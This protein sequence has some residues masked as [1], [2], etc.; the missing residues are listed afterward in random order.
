MGLFGS[1]IG[2]VTSII[3]GNAQKKAASKAAD[4]Q[5]K[6]AQMAIDEQRRQFDTTQQNF[7]PYLGAGTSALDQI[8]SLL[9]I[10]TP[11]NTTTDWGAYAASD[12]QMLAD[13]NSGKVDKTRFPTLDDYA[14]WHYQNYGQA[15][16]RNLSPFN[17]T[18]GGAVD[19]QGAIDALKAS[20]LYSSLYRNGEQAI[21]ANGAA[22]GGLR[23]GNMQNSLANFGADT[24]STVIQNQLANLGGIA[25]MG[26][27]SAG[28]L[29]QFGANMAGQVGN[30]LT[31]Q[32][33]ARAGAALTTGG[34]NAGMASSLGA[35]GGDIFSKIFPNGLNMGGIKF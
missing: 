17:S 21:L 3:G 23:G 29:G 30:A 9:G 16:G 25:N 20:P 19:Q 28:Q 12:P 13:Y 32:G 22:T 2:S 6:A 4:A 8:N 14:Q 26:M 33:Q 34:I 35:L 24:L 11:V 18:T 27:G 31:Q 10:S 15:E 5:V 1:I 7:A